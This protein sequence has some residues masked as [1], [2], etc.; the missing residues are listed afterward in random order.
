MPAL[1]T[2]FHQFL[3]ERQYLYN[4]TPQTLAWYEAA[5]RACTRAVPL[6]TPEAFTTA[7]LQA[8]VVVLR[9]RGVA[10]VTCNTWL[11]ALNVFGG[12]LYEQ[13]HLPHRARLATLRVEK[14]VIETLDDRRLR[15]LLTFQ[16][17]SFSQQRVH[18]LV[19][20]LLDTGCRI[21]EM[22]AARLVDF[23]DDNLL[24]TVMG[25]GRKQR[26][27]P[28]SAELRKRLWRLR[29]AM[30]RIGISSELAFPE[31]HGGPWNQRNALRSY[32]C[33]QR[34]VWQGRSGFHRLRHT[35]A[36][37]YLRA[38]GDVVRLSVILGHTEINT[39]MRYLHLLTDDLQRPHESLSLLNRFR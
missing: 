15:A 18:V 8:F 29:Q 1:E 3:R 32:Y 38:G 23:D 9:D 27:V 33:L 2:L 12:W 13:G 16:P 4:V 11:R 7:A 35:F 22:L 21:G 10:P 25:K 28:F 24:V 30:Q 39:T 5:W 31:R 26:R 17:R 6:A 14:R 34:H 20:A 36:T 19:C 37:R